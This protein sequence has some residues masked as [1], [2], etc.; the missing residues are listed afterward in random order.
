MSQKDENGLTLMELLITV[1]IL[2][3]I[4]A[5]ATPLLSG[6]LDAHRSGAA[7]S[8]LYQEGLLIMETMTAGVRSTVCLF[9]PNADAPTGNILAVSGMINADNDYY[10]GDSLFPQIDDDCN[11]DEIPPSALVYSYNADT[12]T[13]SKI[14]PYPGT[15]TILTENAAFFEVKFEAPDRILIAL[16]LTGEDG[17]SV[18]FSEYACPRNVYH[19]TGKRVR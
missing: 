6:S 13:L 18:T 12:K 15:T 8:R 3:I 17:V 10:F 16:T 9:V 1:T 14:F 7:R 5:V 2:V 4:A 19:R 11:V